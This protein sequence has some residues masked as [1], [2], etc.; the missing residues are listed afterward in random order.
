MP[1]LLQLFLF[2]A[3]LAPAGASQPVTFGSADDPAEVILDP[4]R[5]AAARLAFYGGPSY[6]GVNWR[7]G[8]ALEAEG[9][10]GPFAVRIDGNLRLGLGGVYEPDASEPYDALRLIRYVRLNP[11]PSV[12]LYVRVG[13][14]QRTSFGDGLLVRDLGTYAA[15][16][17][18]TVGVEGA[19]SSR[20]VDV[21]AFTSDVRPDNL[22]GGSVT[23]RPF[24]SR[25]QRGGGTL[26]LRGEGVHDLG[27]RDDVNTTAVAAGL[28]ARISVI[29]DLGIM[30]YVTHA[31][32]LNYGHATSFGAVAGTPDVAG[33]GRASASVG[34]IVRSEQFVPGFF[35]PFYQVHNPNAGIVSSD[36]YFRDRSTQHR[37]G[38]TLD[39]APAG[40]ALTLELNALVYD[41]FEI[42]QFMRR[43]FGGNTGAY[44]LRLIVSPARG[45]DFRLHFEL[46]RQGVAGIRT[47]FSDLVDE[48]LLVFALDYSITEPFRVFLRSRY[49]YT[50]AG[51][52]DDGTTRYLIERRFEPMVGISLVR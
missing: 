36:A 34:L 45:R 39:E 18:R 2:L 51:A 1:K 29:G 40:T 37:V 19:F 4:L 47:L 20:V 13:P 38:T 14:L 30:P 7:A 31:R 41:T 3:V 16:D 17:E 46:H 24:A 26:S 48:A 42:S 49:G 52:F 50:S 11:T 6:I 28:E 23:V 25:R 9:A 33:L 8:V 27:L 35:S 5:A 44:S 32:Y 15:W 21:E 12:P 10:V 22:V 43:D